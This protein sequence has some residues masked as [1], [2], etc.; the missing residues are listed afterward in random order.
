[1]IYNDLELLGIFFVQKVEG[2]ALS[3]TASLWQYYK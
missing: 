1:M 3:F 2:L